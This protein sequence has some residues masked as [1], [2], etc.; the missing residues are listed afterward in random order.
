MVLDQIMMHSGDMI[1]GMAVTVV[2]LVADW[3]SEIFVDLLLRLLP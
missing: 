2:E 3:I 1:L